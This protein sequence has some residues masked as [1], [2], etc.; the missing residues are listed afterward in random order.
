MPRVIADHIVPCVP[1]RH[2]VTPSNESR[3]DVLRRII[4]RVIRH[5]N[6]LAP[7]DP[8]FTSSLGR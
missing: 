4:R 6:M 1:D 5:G 3:G 7:R 8:F 2:G